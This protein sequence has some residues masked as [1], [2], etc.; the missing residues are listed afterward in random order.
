MKQSRR[1]AIIQKQMQPGEIT[2]D[3]MLGTDSR[4]LR[5]I[6]DTDNATVQRLGL[7]HATIAARMREVRNAGAL[8][9]G[10]AISVGDDLEVRVDAARGKLPCPFSHP[11]LYDKEFVEVRHIPSGEQI[12]FS[13]LNI[14][15]IE[16]HGFYEGLG[17]SFRQEPETL[18]RVLGL[19]Q[20][21]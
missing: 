12:I 8:G 18:A 14:H 21:G 6:L 7:D 13:Q 15:L 5:D 4:R 20:K 19:L 11:G 9:L 1:D 2:L 17:A 16:A 10:T 3:G